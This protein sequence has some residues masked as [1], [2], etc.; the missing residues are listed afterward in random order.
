MAVRVKAKGT[1]EKELDPQDQEAPL[2]MAVSPRTETPTKHLNTISRALRVER[3]KMR[4]LLPARC[5]DGGGKRKS[6]DCMLEG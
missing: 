5:G 1:P 2:L 4:T 3:G 6:G